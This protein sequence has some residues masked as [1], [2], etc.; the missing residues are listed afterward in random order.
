MGIGHSEW[1][2][3]RVPFTPLSELPTPPT[4][5]KQGPRGPDRR[6][7]SK[8][9]RERGSDNSSIPTKG[10]LRLHPVFGT[11]KGWGSEAGNQPKTSEQLCKHPSFQDGG[12]TQPENPPK[13]RGLASENGLKGCILLNPHSSRTPEISEFHMGKHLLPIHMPP[14]RSGVSPLGLYQDPETGSSSRERAGDANGMLHRRHPNHGRLEGGSTRPLSRPGVPLTK[15]R[16]HNKPGEDNPGTHS[17][18]RIPRFQSRYSKNGVNS[19][20]RKDKENP[21]GVSEIIRGGARGTVMPHPIQVDWQDECYQPSNPTSP[22]LLQTSPNRPDSSTESFNPGLRLTSDTLPREQRRATLVGYTDGEM[23]W[24]DPDFKNTRS[25][26]RVGCVNP[27]MGSILS[28]LQH[29]RPLVPRG[30]DK[31]HKLPGT[32]SSYTSTEILCEAEDQSISLIKDRQHNS[33]CL[34]Q[35]PR[36]DCIKTVDFPN[37]GL[38]DV[39]SREDHSHPSAT[40]PRSTE[41]GSRHG[42]KD[43]EGQ[44][45]LETGSTGVPQDR[46][47]I[48]SPGRGPFCVQINQSVPSLFQLAARSICRSHRR[49]LPELEWDEGLCQPTLESNTTSTSKGTSGNSSGSPSLESTTMVSSASITTDRLATPVTKT[50]QSN[51]R[52][53]PLL[54]STG[55]MEALRKNFSN[56]GLSNQASELILHSWRT[57]TNKSY[58]SLFAKWHSWCAERGSDPFSGPI[59]EVANFLAS[60]YQKGYQYNSVNAYRSAISSVHERIDGTVVGQHPIITRLLRG[61]YNIRPPLPR[62][63]NTWDVQTVLHY[64]E[65]IEGADTLQLKMLTL[66]TVFLMAI[67]RPSRSADLSQLNINRMRRM[68]DGVSFSPSTLSKQSRQGR[69]IEGF[70]FPR[71]QSNPKLCPVVSLQA[72]LERTEPIRKEETRL[73]LSFIK[74]HAAVSSST[75]ARWLRLTLELA[76]IDSSSPLY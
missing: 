70:H 73:F 21:G 6:G 75:I 66:K 62:Y 19:T 68:S 9:V 4:T 76:G 7:N 63:S 46:G 42:V 65:S 1:V 56:Q 12:D 18:P 52:E 14:V 50:N 35:Q 57:K 74:P 27:R 39:V 69:K 47:D 38:V 36:G 44:I 64:L 67:T 25:G 40:P 30:E 10:L 58:D 45:R 61:I 71:F 23:E 28:G 20:T 72:Y 2:P 5:V 59:S 3:D 41:Q 15:P 34:H 54:P 26:D 11:K 49:S 51:G 31:P 22:P 48:W 17:V 60:L 33:C 24:E 29:G 8:T 43:Y 13:E 55:R 16:L 37:T 53:Q 32:F